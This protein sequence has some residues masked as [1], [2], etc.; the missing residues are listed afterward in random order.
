MKVM[1]DDG[2]GTQIWGSFT[3][4]QSFSTS[5]WLTFIHAINYYTTMEVEKKKKKKTLEFQVSKATKEAKTSIGDL[6]ETVWKSVGI[7]A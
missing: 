4:E 3:L 6:V 5:E 2:I 1:G 7:G